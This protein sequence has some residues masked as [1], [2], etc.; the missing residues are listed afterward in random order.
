MLCAAWSDTLLYWAM[1]HATWE[2]R[3]AKHCAVCLSA[4][5]F[6]FIFYV[7]RPVGAVEADG[8]RQPCTG[9][10]NHIEAG[11]TRLA[12]RASRAHRV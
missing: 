9:L 12:S 1:W 6:C 8:K 7:L 2:K 5:Y 3:I 10:E 11:F 4:S